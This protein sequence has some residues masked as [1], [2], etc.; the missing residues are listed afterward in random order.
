M[1]GN[2]SCA[3][4]LRSC[5][6]EASHLGARA[7]RNRYSRPRD[8]RPASAGAGGTGRS[9]RDRRA[10]PNLRVPGDGQPWPT[11]LTV[12]R[13]RIQ[14]PN[15]TVPPGGVAAGRSCS[16]LP[17]QSL[18]P[19]EAPR[20]YAITNR[21]RTDADMG[22]FAEVVPASA[23]RADRV[24]LRGWIADGQLA[25]RGCVVAGPARFGWACARLG[26]WRRLK[27]WSRTGRGRR[28]M[29]PSTAGGYGPGVCRGGR[30]QGK[31]A[32]GRAADQ[33]RRHR[34]SRY[35]GTGAGG[36]TKRS[37]S[38]PASSRA[39]RTVDSLRCV[40]PTRIRAPLG[41]WSGD[42]RQPSDS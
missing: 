7:E 17:V 2:P 13:P 28:F 12:I 18:H 14:T 4:L 26:G 10:A 11:V 30:R 19:G 42:V 3:W 9:G 39:F 16:R 37:A 35:V 31:R 5:R 32:E 27:N 8:V 20:P 34:H 1:A 40:A 15:G 36:S 38:S 23:C 21:S 6:D 33:R 24:V 22:G 25:N 29:R 41:L